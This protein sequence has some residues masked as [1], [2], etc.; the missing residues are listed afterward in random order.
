MQIIRGIMKSEE[1][2][3]ELKVAIPVIVL[4]AVY[5]LI[6]VISTIFRRGTI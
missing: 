5:L 2:V 1:V 4:L 6:G 3:K